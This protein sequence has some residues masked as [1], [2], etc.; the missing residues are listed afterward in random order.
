M[1][2]WGW[3]GARSP[4]TAPSP[5]SI[6][7]LVPTAHASWPVSRGACPFAAGDILVA[8]ISQTGFC[9]RPGPRASPEGRMLWNRARM[10]PLLAAAGRAQPANRFAVP[11]PTIQV[12]FPLLFSMYLKEKPLMPFLPSAATGAEPEPG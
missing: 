6:P 5:L 2:D 7:V 4:Y 8:L 11:F 3:D 12:Y 10:S 1:W 9:G